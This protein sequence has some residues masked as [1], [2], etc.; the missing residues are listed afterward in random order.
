MKSKNGMVLSMNSKLIYETKRHINGIEY[1]VTIKADTI[2]YTVEIRQPSSYYNCFMK[3][4]Y[5]TKFSHF[6]SAEIY[7]II[8][9][10]AIE[11]WKLLV[12]KFK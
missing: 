10:E 8:V 4:Y 6:K 12:S 7:K 1:M 2:F 9:N 3:Y 5:K 11:Q